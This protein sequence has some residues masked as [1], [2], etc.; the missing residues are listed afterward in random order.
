M[1]FMEFYGI[2]KL[3]F[4]ELKRFF[5]MYIGAWSNNDFFWNVTTRV[6]NVKCTSFHK[7]SQMKA[8]TSG[9]KG[10]QS[11]SIKLFLYVDFYLSLFGVQKVSYFFT[12]K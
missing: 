3:D 9:Y 7:L 5:E 6:F 11:K 8:L 10:D 2:N 4:L 1:E 12:S